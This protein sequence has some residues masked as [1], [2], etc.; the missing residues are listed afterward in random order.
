MTPSLNNGEETTKVVILSI[1]SQRILDGHVDVA[2]RV[3][4][5]LNCILAGV[6]RKMLHAIF[7]MHNIV[8]NVLTENIIIVS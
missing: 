7:Y 1:R 8:T 6:S 4:S 3:N 5:L 2:R